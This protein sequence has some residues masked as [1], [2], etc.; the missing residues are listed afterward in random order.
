MFCLLAPDQL[1]VTSDDQ[2]SIY[3]RQWLPSRYELGSITELIIDED[4]SFDL[5]KKVSFK[6]SAILGTSKFSLMTQT[7]N[8]A[9]MVLYIIPCLFVMLSQFTY[10]CSLS[11]FQSFRFLR[12][13]KSQKKM[14]SSA[15]CVECYCM[16]NIENEQ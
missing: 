4:S 10:C 9:M 11:W 8:D 13:V 5:I 2:L 15:R 7:A 16:Y 1:R 14:Y 6:F 3:V 12:L